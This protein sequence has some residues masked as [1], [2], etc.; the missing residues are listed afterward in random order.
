MGR[1]ELAENES[2]FVPE[3]VLIMGTSP[4]PK[5]AHLNKA[6]SS[7]KPEA[8][9]STASGV[10]T[11]LSANMARYRSNRGTLVSRRVERKA[12]T[13][14]AATPVGLGFPDS[15]PELGGAGSMDVYVLHDD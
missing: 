5:K 7:A 4:S 3:E 2:N 14:S 8:R 12:C 13:S 9:A 1:Q 11:F 15:K 6:L 10:P